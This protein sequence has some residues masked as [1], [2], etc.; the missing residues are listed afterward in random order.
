MSQHQHAKHSSSEDRASVVLRSGRFDRLTVAQARVVID[1]DYDLTRTP[2]ARRFYMGTWLQAGHYFFGPGRGGSPVSLPRAVR[3]ETFLPWG[4]CDGRLNPSEIE[5]EA[6]L[7][8]A[9]DAEGVWWT[10]IG[11]A[12]RTDDKRGGCNANFLFDSRLS[13][14]EALDDARKHFSKVFERFDFEVRDVAAVGQ[15]HPPA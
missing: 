2:V 3:P 15:E 8:H 6:A 7:H 12:N 13:F 1:S 11:F 4:Y 9:R 14:D 10:G 5:G